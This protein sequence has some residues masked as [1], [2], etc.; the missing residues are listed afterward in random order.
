MEN[1]NSATSVIDDMKD[2][3]EDIEMAIKLK[4]AQMEAN[5]ELWKNE[6]NSLGEEAKRKFSY[7]L[8]LLE[9][10]LMKQKKNLEETNIF[11]DTWDVMKSEAEELSQEI[12]TIYKKIKKSL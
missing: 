2:V 11:S 12:E 9:R 6:I 5:I 7:Y 8:T 3:K 10:K 1:D 4:I